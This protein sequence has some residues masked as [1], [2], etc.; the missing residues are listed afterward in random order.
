VSDTFFTASPDWGWYI[1]LYFF[2][3]GIA[4]GCFFLSALLRVLGKPEDLPAARLGAYVAFAGAALSGILLTLDLRRPE[5][6]WH[7][8]LQSHTGAPM[9][10]PWSPM[11][12]GAWG[13]LLFSGFAFLATVQGMV[14]E[15][16]LRWSGLRLLPRKGPSFVIHVPGSAFGFFLAGYTGVLLAVSNRPMWADSQL[17]GL[18]FLV[19]AGST[20]AATLILLGRRLGRGHPAL[21]EWL[22]RFDGRVLLFELVVLG[23]FLVSLGSV[24]RVLLNGW[25]LLLGI[26]TVGLGIAL[27]LWLERRDRPA[28]GDGRQVG[29][30]AALVLFGGFILRVV[31]ILASEQVELGGAGIAGP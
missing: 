1:I 6:F 17:L 27:P 26:G 23:A 4:G 18:L 16:R 29:T 15:G 14:E 8:L 28:R 10:K 24:I 31:V 22:S 19:S 7:M 13:L 21:F 3:G 12:V 25:G 30:A 11:S 20:A 2:V 9:L 5:R